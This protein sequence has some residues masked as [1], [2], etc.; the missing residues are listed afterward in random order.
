MELIANWAKTRKRHEPERQEVQIVLEVVIAFGVGVL[1]GVGM[2]CCL[3]MAGRTDREM[4]L[5]KLREENID[6]GTDVS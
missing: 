6:D 4:E 3:V 2:T 1:F 5:D